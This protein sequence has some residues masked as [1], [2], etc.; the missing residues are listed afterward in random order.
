VLDL[1]PLEGDALNTALAE[2]RTASA[3]RQVLD[4]PAA[5]SGAA[6]GIAE[7]LLAWIGARQQ[8]TA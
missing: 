1:R 4:R 6:A 8:A 3:D 7:R 5:A 2:A